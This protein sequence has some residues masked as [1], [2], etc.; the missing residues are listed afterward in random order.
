MIQQIKIPNYTQESKDESKDNL[1][2]KWTVIR[3]K[4][5]SIEQSGYNWSV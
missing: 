2:T 3:S 5:N 4:R 1:N